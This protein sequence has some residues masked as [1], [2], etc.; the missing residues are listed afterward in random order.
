MGKSRQPKT[1][2]SAFLNQPE[3]R[4][5]VFIKDFTVLAFCK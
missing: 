4:F 5:Y 2:K 1:N 3:M